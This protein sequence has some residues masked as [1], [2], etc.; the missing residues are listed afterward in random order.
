MKKKSLL[1][2]AALI[3]IPL[4]AATV[5]LYPERKGASPPLPEAVPASEV[6]TI[7]QIGRA[8]APPTPGAGRVTAPAAA[9]PADDGQW[10]MPAKNYAATRYSAMAEIQPGNVRNLRE[11]FSFS[12]G[13]TKGEE[14]APLVVNNVMYV[15]TAYPNYLY[16]LDLAKTGAL[17]WKFAPK[18]LP[19][20]Q[21]VACCDVVNRGAAYADGKIVFNTL[22]GQTIAVD[23]ATGKPVWRTQLGNINKGES[24]TM[25]PLIADGK[26]LVGDSGGEFGVR[27]WLTALDLSDGRIAWRAYHTGPDRD[28]LIGPGFRPFYAMD[29]GTDLGIKTWPADHWRI[30]GGTMWGWIGYN[31]ETKTIYYGTGNPGPWNAQD[32]PGDNE[33][34]AGLFARDVDTGQA[35]WFYHT[36]PHDEHDYDNINEQILL[37]MPFGGKMRQVLVRLER[38]GYVYVIDRNNG[39]V[40]SAD[41][42]GPVNSTKGV[43]LKTG[44]I[45]I[46]P[47]KETKLGQVVRNICPTASGA[48]D[49]NPSSFSPRLGLIFIPHENLCMDWQNLQAN[50]ISGTPYVGAE[51][52]MKPGPGGFRGQLTAWDPVL[53]RPRWQ[54]EE[55]LPIWSGTVATAGDLVFYGTMDGWFKAVDA[56]AGRVIWQAKLDSG[57]ISQ[58]ISYRGPDGHQYIA[59]LTGVGGWSGAIVSGPL[60]PRDPSGALGFVAT[61][62]D[63]PHRTTPGGTLHVFALPH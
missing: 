32:R 52:K 45:I 62:T 53:R 25:A 48:K 39:Q 5:A 43:D 23:A 46:N 37:D 38:D 10:V 50:Y 36:T 22:D 14:A 34:T 49:W 1:I 33:W 12:L 7:D 57:I 17:K 30:G 21:G 54:I 51:V 44:R 28:V 6:F 18:P 19:A 55:D 58:P 27:G 16:A 60:D 47:A 8:L 26:V 2:G 35:K 59:V 31:P 9:A 20:S 40:L 3:A 13:V 42:F 29:R 41:P 11:V 24:I 15:V 61:M 63:L 4:A 56:R